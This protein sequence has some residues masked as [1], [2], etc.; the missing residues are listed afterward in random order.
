[1]LPSLPYILTRRMLELV[2][3]RLAAHHDN[4]RTGAPVSSAGPSGID[5]SPDQTVATS[6]R[7]APRAV[8]RGQ[9]VI[10]FNP[11]G[12]VGKT[13][14]AVNLAALLQ[15]RKGQRVLIIDA[16]TVTGHI[17]ARTG[18]R[19]RRSRARER[20]LRGCVAGCRL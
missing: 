10:V 6:A 20:P 12:G 17:A 8:G 11:K 1:M 7:P 19:Q 13:T 16:D 5:N 9:V 4:A 2:A 15:L 3:L 14:I 18:S